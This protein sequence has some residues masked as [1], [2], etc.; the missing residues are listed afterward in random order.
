MYPL[1]TR[2]VTVFFLCFYAFS[3]LITSHLVYL[4]GLWSKYLTLQLLFLYSSTQSPRD[5]TSSLLKCKFNHFVALHTYTHTYVLYMLYLYVI[6][7]ICIYTCI[8]IYTRICVYTYI[9]VYVYIR[10]YIYICYNLY[11]SVCY[12]FLRGILYSDFNNLKLLLSVLED[13]Q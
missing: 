13:H 3:T 10:V 2:I 8:Y 4:N 1:G 11:V 7:V 9:H 5:P 12:N 6:C